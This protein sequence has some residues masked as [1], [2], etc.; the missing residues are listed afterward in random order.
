MCKCGG[1]E[2]AWEVGCQGPGYRGCT[3]GV[4]VVEDLKKAYV[5]EE[6]PCDPSP[7][8]CIAPTVPCL[9]CL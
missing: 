8:T 1:Q 3:G 7:Q 5:G 4:R 2:Q 6:V 9:F